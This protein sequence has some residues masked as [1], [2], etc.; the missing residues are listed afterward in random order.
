MALALLKGAIPKFILF[1]TSITTFNCEVGIVFF[2]VLKEKVLRIVG[3]ELLMGY[4]DRNNYDKE[5]QEAL[6]NLL[7]P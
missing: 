4:M 5:P 3:S 7:H 6:R 1:F 2:G